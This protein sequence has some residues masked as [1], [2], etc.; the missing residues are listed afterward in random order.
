MYTLCYSARAGDPV[1]ERPQLVG[2]E[3]AMLFVADWTSGS[4]A[5]RLLALHRMDPEP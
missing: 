4:Y 5:P 1:R 3:R 2:A